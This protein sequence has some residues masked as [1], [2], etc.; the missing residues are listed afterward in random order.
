MRCP[1][2]IMVYIIAIQYPVPPTQKQNIVFT[3]KMLTNQILWKLNSK[4]SAGKFFKTK[5]HFK[6]KGL[7]EHVP[8]TLKN[9]L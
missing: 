9:L 8:I 1:M 4:K 5:H 2:L 7:E 6:Q 3:K